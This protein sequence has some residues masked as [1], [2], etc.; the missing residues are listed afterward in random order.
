MRATPAAIERP[1]TTPQLQRIVD[2]ALAAGR[3]LKAIGAGHSFT[4]IAVADDIQL[5]LSQYTGIIALDPA[6][7]RV[8]LRSGTRL[9]QIPELLADTGLGMQNLGDIIQQSIAGAISTGTHGTGLT[10]GGLG[11]QVVG[12]EMLTGTG[13]TLRVCLEEQPELLD[14]LRVSLGA[15]GIIT[16]VT[17]QL[18]PE[19]ELHTVEHPMPL[20]QV[21]DQWHELNAAHDHAEFFWFGHDRRVVAKTSQRLPVQQ[22]PAS[23]LATLRR[24]LVD[25]L[26]ENVA[27]GAVCQLGRLQPAWTPGLNRLCTVA[28]GTRQDRAHW[29]TAFA[30]PRRVR[31]NEM[32]YALAFDAIPEVLRELQVMFDAGQLTSTFPLEI[33]SAA[34]GPG[35]LATNHGQ[36][37]GYIAVHQHYRQDHRELFGRIEPVFRAAG[38]RPH[39]GKL[40]TM[41]ADDLAGRYPRWHDML[42]LRDTLDPDRVFGNAYLTQVLGA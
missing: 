17:L 22:R 10:F 21:I 40:H 27:L 6:R 36:T 11:A 16:S 30:S 15:M 28:W 13:E 24:W 41:D 4:E 20:A 26:F 37:T 1:T 29:S 14:A 12:L 7:Q 2:D 3:R 35:W 42:A 33:R 31:F 8:T 19:Y 18:V 23:R 25:D 32:E 34:P 9:W 39:W 38:G 5:D